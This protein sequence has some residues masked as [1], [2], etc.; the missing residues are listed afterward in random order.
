[1]VDDKKIAAILKSEADPQAACKTL[2][3]AANDAG[4]HD[5]ITTLI[6]DYLSS[7]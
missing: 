1:M 5:N 4:G 3:K 6:I 7:K 2:I